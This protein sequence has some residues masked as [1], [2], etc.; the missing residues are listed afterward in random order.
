INERAL[1]RPVYRARCAR[2]RLAIAACAVGAELRSRRAAREDLELVNEGPAHDHLHSNRRARTFARKSPREKRKTGPARRWRGRQ[3][4]LPVAPGRSTV[5]ARARE[6]SPRHAGRY[7]HAVNAIDI[8]NEKSVHRHV[9][10]ADAWRP[11][12]RDDGVRLLAGERSETRTDAELERVVDL[13]AQKPV[14]GREHL[15]LLEAGQNDVAK[16]DDVEPGVTD[17]A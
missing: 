10:A 16:E 3:P 17:E 9:K 5:Q 1:F 13:E 14:R 8:R 6:P 12:G 11:T 15:A 4:A 2:R 7:A